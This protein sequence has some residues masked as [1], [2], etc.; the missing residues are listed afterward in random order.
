M[1]EKSPRKGNEKKKGKTLKEKQHAKKV[2]RVLKAGRTSNIPP[3][4][5]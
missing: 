1:S 2:Q 3:T 4:G 5:H